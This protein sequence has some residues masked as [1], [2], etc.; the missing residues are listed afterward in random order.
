MSDTIREA[1][2]ELVALA[3]LREPS[4]DPQWDA[5]RAAQTARLREVCAQIDALQLEAS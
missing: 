2:A 3:G 1:L 4:G 5:A